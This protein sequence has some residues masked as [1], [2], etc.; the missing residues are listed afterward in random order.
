MMCL[1]VADLPFG[2]AWEYEVKF[3]GYRAIGFKTRGRV[4]LMSRNGKDF[5]PRFRTLTSALE[6]LP[7]D[8]AIDGEVVALDGTG[9]PSFNLLQNH[10]SSAYSLVFTCS[11]F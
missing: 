4:H 3:D 10:L 11:I 7:D 1:G 5:S 6:A 2:P 8:T 9:R